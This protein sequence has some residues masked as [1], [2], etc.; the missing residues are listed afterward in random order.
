MDQEPV[1]DIPDKK[2]D[3]ETLAHPVVAFLIPT[4]KTPYLT[5]DLLSAALTSGKYAG[6]TFVLLLDIG[7]P[8]LLM[9]K[10]LVDNVRTKGLS[11][12]F[13]IFDGTPYCGKVNRVAPIVTADCVCVIDSQHLPVAGNGVPFADAVRNWLASSIEPMRVG[14][15]VTD[16]FYPLVTRK[17]VDRLGYMFHP[18]CYGRIEAEGWLLSLADALGILSPVPDGNV[19]ESSTDGVEIEGDSTQEDASWVDET[20]KQTLDDEVARLASYLVH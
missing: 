20:L 15:F 12:G 18:L 3:G 4:Y 16:G 1:N 9:Y 6:C 11:A 2:N 19:I 13:F 5:S 7:D 8:N 17:L 10:T 14:T